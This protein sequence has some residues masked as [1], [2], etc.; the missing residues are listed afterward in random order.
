M[1]VF[2]YGILI[3]FSGFY[4]GIVVGTFNT[5]F[6]PFMENQYEIFSESW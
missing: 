1:K 2:I 3:S 4:F 5:F 6:E